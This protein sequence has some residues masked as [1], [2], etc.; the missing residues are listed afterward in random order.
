MVVLEP[1]EGPLRTQPNLSLVP[2]VRRTPLVD[3]TVWERKKQPAASS[4][5]SSSNSGLKK[6]NFINY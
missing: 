3:R 2:K 6:S 5:A 1:E 4:T